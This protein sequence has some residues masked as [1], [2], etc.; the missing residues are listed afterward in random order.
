MMQTPKS[1]WTTINLH[2]D[3]PGNPSSPV[4][5]VPL[6]LALEVLTHHVL[7]SQRCYPPEAFACRPIL[8]LLSPS[9]PTSAPATY[10]RC[11]H[12]DVA[13]YI[14]SHLSSSPPSFPPSRLR[15]L[16]VHTTE[17]RKFT[18]TFRGSSFLDVEIA[19]LQILLSRVGALGPPQADS[20]CM[21]VGPAFEINVELT[22]E[23][24]DDDVSLDNLWNCAVSTSMT[25]SLPLQ[26][27]D[28]DPQPQLM[29]LLSHKSQKAKSVLATFCVRK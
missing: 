3:S 4:S 2:D 17:T 11:V 20:A 9:K 10:M 1:Q 23:G 24:E 18:F 14:S 19:A 25:S 12:P 15:S 13:A 8:T 7:H 5:T 21:D 22:A 26:E 28:R 6:P 29:V 16:I 27:P